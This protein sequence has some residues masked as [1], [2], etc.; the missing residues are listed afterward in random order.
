M[1]ISLTGQT[2]A[3]WKMPFELVT[4]ARNL[5][6]GAEWVWLARGT[7]QWLKRHRRCFLTHRNSP[8]CIARSHPPR[9]GRLSSRLSQ[10]AAESAQAAYRTAQTGRLTND[11]HVFL[12]VQEAASPRSRCRRIQCL[13][14]SHFL[15]HRQPSPPGGLMCMVASLSSLVYGH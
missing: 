4:R 14:R 7:V 1:Q 15:V 11:R 13:V 3:I 8:A 2:F 9:S 12:T 10:M 5:S 6:S